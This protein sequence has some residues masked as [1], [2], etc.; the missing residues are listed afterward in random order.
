MAQAD[1]SATLFSLRSTAN[2]AAAIAAISQT[3]F[4]PRTINSRT[5]I[6]SATTQKKI[7]KHYHAVN[8]DISV[9]FKS[10]CPG[11]GTDGHP[12]K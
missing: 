3:L 4:T 7:G 10:T 9:N 2:T 11:V 1:G 12:G 6:A 5:V 8:W